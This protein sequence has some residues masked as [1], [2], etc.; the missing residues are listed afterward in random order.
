M[1]KIIVTVVALLVLGKILN[2]QLIDKYGVSLG[3][4]Y[5]MQTWGEMKWSTWQKDKDYRLGL[6]AF[7]FAEKELGKI[8][9]IKSNIGY[10]QKGFNETLE[11][12]HLEGPVTQAEGNGVRFHNLAMSLVLKTS[13]F[14]SKVLPY[15]IIGLR[16]DYLLS[17][18][19]SYYVEPGSEKWFPIYESFLRDYRRFNVGVLAG[20]GMDI[21]DMFFIEFEFNTTLTHNSHW[22][23]KIKDKCLGIKLGVYL[24]RLI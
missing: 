2:A 19:D 22:E 23:T 6:M 11:F 18:D 3:T 12:N 4:T 7:I 5:S 20:I 10:I 13:P 24:N 9:G 17:Y 1:K 8:L 14:Q 21:N 16:G 15:A